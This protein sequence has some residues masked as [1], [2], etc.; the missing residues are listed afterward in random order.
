LPFGPVFDAVVVDA[1]CSGLGTVRRDPDIKWRRTEADLAGFATAQLTML[2]QAATVVRPGGYLLYATCSSEPDENQ[3]VVD[4]FL[5]IRPAF[6]AAPL[7]LSGSALPRAVVNR[8]AALETSPDRH[9]LEA[10][11]G[12][13]LVRQR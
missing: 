3:Q 4:Q 11:F 13:M 7:P 10:F 1:P 2:Q 9:G 8:E 12:A 6:V 5:S